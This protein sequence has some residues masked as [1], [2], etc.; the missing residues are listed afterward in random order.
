M[1]L[2]STKQQSQKTKI[3]KCSYEKGGVENFNGI[4]R[5]YIPKNKDIKSISRQK[6]QAINKQINDTPRK[7]LNY[8]TPVEMFLE[9]IA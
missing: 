9:Y 6:I 1:V 2:S 4:I 7:I 5:R 8:K 3:Y